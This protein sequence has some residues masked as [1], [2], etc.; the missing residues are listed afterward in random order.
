MW[1]GIL[2]AEIDDCKQVSWQSLE[3]LS[4]LD[5]L[6]IYWSILCMI[7]QFYACFPH[8]SFSILPCAIWQFWLP[9]QTYI[10]IHSDQREGE[11]EGFS[12]GQQNSFAMLLEGR[13]FASI[14]HVEYCIFNPF[15]LNVLPNGGIFFSGHF[16]M[17]LEVGGKP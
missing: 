8:K 4:S 7:I 14:I 1:R 9:A 10:K 5:A 2:T 12:R 11:R 15:F 16:A 6:Y 17:V 13:H 3:K